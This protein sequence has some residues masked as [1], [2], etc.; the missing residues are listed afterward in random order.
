MNKK[1]L[2]LFI[3]L[4]YFLSFIPHVVQH[5]QNKNIEC[6]FLYSRYKNLQQVTSKN[7]VGIKCMF[8][9]FKTDIKASRK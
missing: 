3:F 7:D 6:N 8:L 1:S 4:K 2:F 9:N 5:Y